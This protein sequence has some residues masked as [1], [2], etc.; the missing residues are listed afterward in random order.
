MDY[1]ASLYLGQRIVYDLC[2]RQNRDN[3]YRRDA[4]RCL[5][6]QC[7]CPSIRLSFCPPR[8]VIVSKRLNWLLTPIYYVTAP[9]TWFLWLIGVTNFRRITTE[10][11][12]QAFSI[13]I[14]VLSYTYIYNTFASFDYDYGVINNADDVLL[15]FMCDQ[16][17]GDTLHLILRYTLFSSPLVYLTWQFERRANSVY[18]LPLSVRYFVIADGRRSCRHLGRIH[19]PS[20]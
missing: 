12:K 6:P 19:V 15:I 9:S 5:L 14:S 13:E 8:S 20:F 16:Q 11:Y 2:Q 3:V 4:M 18:F 10:A 7:I 17:G 1:V